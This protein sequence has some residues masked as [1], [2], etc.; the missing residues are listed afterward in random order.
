MN[1][2]LCTYTGK[3]FDLLNPDPALVDIVDIA[4]GLSKQC[5]FNGHCLRFYSVAQHSVAVSYLVP[6][7]HA[8]HGLLHDAAEAYIG[9]VIAP[10]KQLLPDYKQIEKTV[11]QAIFSAFRLPSLLPHCVKKADAIM[12]F[13]ERR[14]LMPKTD[15]E[16][17]NPMGV[18]PL[19]N[20]IDTW[21]HNSSR[22]LFLKRFKELTGCKELVVR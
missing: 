4:N 7:E 18:Y 1:A 9:D 22:F 8:L 19:D 17:D 15:V 20:P 13:T 16:W 14:D 5:R 2:E 12:L 10:L 6:E 21:N 11:E 3:Y